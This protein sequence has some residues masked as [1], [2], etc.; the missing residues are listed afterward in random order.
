M[1]LRAVA[2]GGAIGVVLALAKGIVCVVFGCGGPISSSIR[3]VLL[4]LFDRVVDSWSLFSVWLD[5]LRTFAAVLL[6]ADTLD[7]VV[8][9]IRLASLCSLFYALSKVTRMVVHSAAGML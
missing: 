2:Y 4:Q 9:V 7:I 8:G 3:D 1:F 6:S 5:N